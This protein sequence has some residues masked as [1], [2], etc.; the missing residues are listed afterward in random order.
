[1]YRVLCLNH[2]L[3]SMDLRQVWQKTLYLWSRFHFLTNLSQILIQAQA[4]GC[5]QNTV[6]CYMQLC[7]LAFLPYRDHISSSPFQRTFL[8][9]KDGLLICYSIWVRVAVWTT[10]PYKNIYSYFAGQDVL[11]KVDGSHWNGHTG[12]S[13]GYNFNQ[14]KQYTL[15]TDHCENSQNKEQLHS[16]LSKLGKSLR[17]MSYYNLQLYAIFDCIFCNI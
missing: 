4:P 2:L 9:L 3:T 10:R 16:T 11:V 1:M 8:R 6:L 5:Q 7:I 13:D 15:K 14:H 17:Q 12:C